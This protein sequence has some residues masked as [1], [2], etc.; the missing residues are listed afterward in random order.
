MKLSF[1]GVCICILGSITILYPAI[2]DEIVLQT[3]QSDFY[4]VTGQTAEIPLTIQ[5]SYPDSVPGM[6]FYSMTQALNTQG[7]TSSYTN[8]QQENYRINPGRT[9]TSLLVGSQNA[10]GDVD[11]LLS[12]EYTDENGPKTVQLPPITI[13]FVSDESQAEHKSN[14]Q[15]STTTQGSASSTALG[16]SQS[17][18]TTD[19]LAQMQQDMM[20]MQQMSTQSM[21][22]SYNQPRSASQALQNNQMNANTASLAQQM[23]KE[24]SEKE[25]LKQALTETLQKDPLFLKAHDLVSQSGYEVVSSSVVPKTD[26][27]G[28][29]MIQ[30]KNPAG[31]LL[32]LSGEIEDGSVSSVVIEGEIEKTRAE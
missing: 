32:H 14:P 20:Q 18:S 2:A 5:S 10:G 30:Y 3:N 31:S 12:F 13:H 7:F 25:D 26:T 15:S 8:S 6:L 29:F 11:L 9:D 19:M 27:R 1:I 4:V 28:T 21:Q 16:S 22:S 23:A 24:S 17:T